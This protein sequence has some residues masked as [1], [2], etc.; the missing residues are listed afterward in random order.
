MDMNV[1]IC[2]HTYVRIYTHTH[3]HSES[4]LDIIQGEVVRRRKKNQVESDPFEDLLGT[5]QAIARLRWSQELNPLYDSIKGMRIID[6]IGETDVK[7]YFADEAGGAGDKSCVEQ[8]PDFTGTRKMKKLPS[9]IL[10]E[11]ESESAMA[12]GEVKPGGEQIHIP[13]I[14]RSSAEGEE[15]EVEQEEVEEEK[16]EKKAEGEEEKAA[17]ANKSL[18]LPRRRQHLYEEVNFDIPRLSE[19]KSI[20]AINLSQIHPLPKSGEVELGGLDSKSSTLAAINP[21]VRRLQHLGGPQERL[22]SISPRLGKRQLQR[23]SRTIGCVDDT[24][25]VTRKQK[26]LR[27]S[28]A[29][30]VHVHLCLCELCE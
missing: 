8:R 22:G 28:D 27:V 5:P 25:A 12:A 10:E 17:K 1:R 9:M 3:T 21:A 19:N 30:K 26:P 15:Q 20:S 11:Y 14:T 2:I 23:R 4:N 16:D 29:M 18:S 7:F 13:L 24:E 6:S